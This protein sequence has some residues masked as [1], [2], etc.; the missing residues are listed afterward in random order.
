MPTPCQPQHANPMRPYANPMPT[1]CQPHANPMPTPCQPHA[2]PMPTP[3]QPQPHMP[4]PC[5]PHANPVLTPFVGVFRRG[6]PLHLRAPQPQR[7]QQNPTCAAWGNLGA[8]LCF[9]G[10]VG[11]GAGDQHQTSGGDPW[12]RTSWRAPLAWDLC[13]AVEPPI[14]WV[15][16]AR[17][18]NATA[19]ILANAPTR[20]TTGLYIPRIQVSATNVVR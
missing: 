8:P 9:N 7:T 16:L 19:G 15:G 5:Q 20:A 11:S 14:R 10:R 12:A 18:A 17:A 2:G 4:T 13:V 6:G 3:C 1:P